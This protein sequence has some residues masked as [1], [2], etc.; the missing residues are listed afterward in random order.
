MTEGGRTENGSSVEG[1]R[2]TAEERT[3]ARKVK[4]K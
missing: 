3:E 4:V 2:H 1:G